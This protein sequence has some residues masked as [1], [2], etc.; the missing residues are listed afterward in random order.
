MGQEG[1]TRL[2]L[3]EGWAVAAPAAAS[4]PGAAERD[5]AGR[6]APGVVCGVPLQRALVGGLKQRGCHR[7]GRLEQLGLWRHAVLSQSGKHGG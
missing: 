5:G 4:S 2:G 6:A 1:Q 7:E 3:A